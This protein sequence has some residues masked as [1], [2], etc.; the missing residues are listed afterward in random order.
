MKQLFLLP[1]LLMAP[2]HAQQT[3]V[4]DTCTRIQETYV[5]GY[6]NPDGSWVNG[7]VRREKFTIPCN[8]QPTQQTTVVA[9]PQPVYYRRRSCNPTA[10]ALL[11]A[12]L[13][14]ALSGNSW[15]NGGSWNRSWTRNSS[16]GSWSNY[17]RNNYWPLFGAGLGALAFS[18]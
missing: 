12:G 13:A 17:G 6:Q 4:Y 16:S 11:G 14:G 5:P 8:S 2:V 18:C 15:S 1:I 10:G 9:N 3:V 7:I